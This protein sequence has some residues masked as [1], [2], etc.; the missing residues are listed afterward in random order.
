MD[1]IRTAWLLP[2]SLTIASAPAQSAWMRAESR[3]FIVYEDADAA[4]VRDAAER[5]EKLNMVQHALTGAADKAPPMKVRVY[6]LANNDRVQATMP[7][8][9]M[10]VSG[11]YNASVR[12]PYAVNTRAND[13]FNRF[14][15]Q[16]VLFHELTHH[17][18]R[19]YFS[20][21]YPIWYSEGF[22]DFVGGTTIDPGNAIT[23]GAPV[24]NRYFS[25]RGLRAEQWIPA[26]VLLS[27][28][29]Y[30]DTN[31][32]LDLLYAEGWLLTHY[33]TI[34]GQRKGQLVAYLKAVNA[35]R[36][37]EMAAKDAFGDLDA[38]NH[39]LKVYAKLNK[40]PAKV[41][42]FA[43]IEPGDIAVTPVSDAQ[44]AL[45]IVDIRLSGGIP[46][47]D[48]DEFAASVRKIANGF[49]E[50]RVALRL[51][52]EADRLA[53]DRSDR[54]NALI[55]WSA[56]SPSDPDLLFQQAMLQADELVAS[57]V[58]DKARWD[59]IRASLLAAHK[60]A[61]NDPAILKAYY[62]TYKQQGIEPTPGAQNALFRALDI[63]PQDDE[64]RY[65]LAAD[66]EHRKQF[67][68]AIITI[69][70]AALQTEDATKPWQKARDER[71]RAKYRFAGIALHETP[72]EMLT[73]LEKELAAEAV[74]G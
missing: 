36:T 64:V 60:R 28:H 57:K 33:L 53:G 47:N 51:R 15:A 63:V 61:L 13:R 65:E 23:L 18:M 19:Q 5:L 17:F 6:L 44:A 8:G 70:P 71:L 37:Y 27:A 41:I 12:G 3:N 69:R 34:S 66:F 24:D 25:L 1:R 74:P 10:G 55:R 49:P 38:L 32:R 26:K 40:L 16:L 9:G 39:E 72:R 67:K 14:P 43:T 73:R 62:D 2:L 50:D 42:T 11:Y 7:F 29:S 4:T 22:A 52:I 30:A 21:A 54:S 46:A 68:D 58:T 56:L 35:G 20:A 48:A 59:G 45:M 31:G